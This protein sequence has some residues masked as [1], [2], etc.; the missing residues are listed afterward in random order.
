VIANTLSFETYAANN[1]AVIPEPYYWKDFIIFFQDL[2]IASP[3]VVLVLILI[4][5]APNSDEIIKN[6]NSEKSDTKLN[7]LLFR[8]RVS[9]FSNYIAV[10]LFTVL[11]LIVLRINL[12]EINIFKFIVKFFTASIELHAENSIRTVNIE[13]YAE[14]SVRMLFIVM[15]GFY[16]FIGITVIPIK[17]I[18]KALDCY[19]EKTGKK[20]SIITRWKYRLLLFIPIINIV[21]IY[22]IER[23]IK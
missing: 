7:I 16:Y 3:M 21:G 2:I 1:T 19:Y 18:T 5:S 22:K 13:L 14:N 15:L 12:F 11:I 20:R 8:A 23:R 4:L 9:L 10:I 6:N 17:Y